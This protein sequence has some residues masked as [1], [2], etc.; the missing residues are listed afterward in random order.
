MLTN[1]RR[2]IF[3]TPGKIVALLL[4]V[5]LG[6]GFAM[7]DVQN[8]GVGG[9]ST[10]GPLV[11]VGERKLT[12]QELQDRLS[13][14]LDRVRE[15]QPMLDMAQFVRT[16]GFDQV[17]N[18][19]IDGMALEEYARQQGMA[20]S[21]AAIDGQI[22]SL[23]GFQGFDGKFS[24]QRFD[25]FLQDQRLTAE[26]VRADIRRQTMIQWL[27]EPL[28]VA[29]PVP[30]E[31]ALPYAS[32]QLERRKGSVGYVPIGAIAPGTPPTAAELQTY[33]QRNSARYTLPERRVMRYAVVSPAQFAETTKATDAEI[34][35]EY[36]RNASQYAASTRRNLAQ[37]IVASEATAKQIAEK[38][39]AGTAMADAARAAGLQASTIPNAEQQAFAKASSPAI[40]TA[41]FAG[42]EGTVVGPLRSPLG[43]HIVRVEKIEQVAGKT[44]DQ[45]RGELAEAL[46]QR[47]LAEALA[48]L[49]ARIDSGIAG[50]STFDELVADAKLQ[51]QTSAPLFADG[52]PAP[53]TD[54]A[55]DP[56]L[57]QIAQAGFSMETGDDP[58]LAP[59]GTDGGFALVKTE[60]VVAAAPRPLAEIRPTVA[61]DLVRSRQLEGARKAAN[62]ILAKVNKGMPIAQAMQESGLKLP[63]VQPLDAMRGQIAQMGDQLPPPVRL[64]FSMAANTAKTVA[65]PQG[66]GY[67]IVR[68]DAIE[69]GNARGNAALIAQTRGGLGQLIG[70]EYVEQ[71][72]AAA[73]KA[74]TVK[75]NEAAI[76]RVRAQ[77]SG[78]ASGGN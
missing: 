5:A 3:S 52:R 77:L 21:P 39:K 23:P 30:T 49:R 68:L 66:G 38:V 69:P 64:M 41:A 72:A 22:A 27:I 35:A 75:R 62:A 31:F 61:D 73:R 45:V 29:G 20:V 74:V 47:K 14:A 37:I 6:V 16:G 8:L 26:Q 43:W 25:Q 9:P 44:L 65:A 67:W 57:A 48:D 19:V 55:P 70:D 63:A 50:N 56:V 13:N 1:L 58:Q 17:L 33:Y 28:A 11:E 7:M 4:L 18:Q 46:S 60:R 76:A 78:Q 36:K 59:I 53:A 32:L 54:A 10:G 12:E 24:Q 2:V 34:A 40:A 42:G 15:Q 51:P 71:F